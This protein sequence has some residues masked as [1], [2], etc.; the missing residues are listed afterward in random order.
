MK[1]RYAFLLGSFAALT[2][3]GQV[4]DNNTP[5]QPGIF[6]YV[7]IMPTA[8]YDY[9]EFLSK[10]LHYPERAHRKNIEGRVLIKFVVNEDGSITDCEV[11]QSVSPDLDNAALSVVKSLPT[12]QPGTQNG[13]KV[14]VYFTLPIVFKLEKSKK[15]NMHAG[16][17]R[18]AEHMPEPTFDMNQYLAD[19]LVIP[20]KSKQAGTV[21]VTF[22]VNEDGTTTDFEVTGGIDKRCDR[23]AKRVLKNMPAWKPG[24]QNG[25][26]VKT[27]VTQS[28]VFEKP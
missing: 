23:E 3:H 27:F 20:K 8:G 4:P 22:I 28:V 18:K 6:K 16:V 25:R 26:A 9:Q 15:F 2:A 1:L 10:N 7:D 24:I 21:D 11:A 5:T 13:K 12:W 14:K 17:L 19:N